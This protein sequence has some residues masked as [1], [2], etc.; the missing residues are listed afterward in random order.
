LPAAAA[1][2]A[3]LAAACGFDVAVNYISNAKAANEVGAA[4]KKSG[5]KAVTLQG[6]MAKEADIVRVFD[7][8]TRSLGPISTHHTAVADSAA[9][10]AQRNS[11]GGAFPALGRRVLHQRRGAQCLG[12]A[13]T[14]T[15]KVDEHRLAVTALPPKADSR[16]QSRD[17]RLGPIVLQ[18]SKVA[19]LRIFRENTKR[20]AIADSYNLNRV[21]EVACEFN[22]RR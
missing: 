15:I 13:L 5:G 10:P 16:P 9:G 12:R 17:V 22:V 21:T 20:K 18:K 11:R 19:G 6:D 14:Q 1:A 2:S 7:E 4:V 8:T 3:R